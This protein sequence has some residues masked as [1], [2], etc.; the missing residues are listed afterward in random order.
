MGA[1][2]SPPP[3][4]SPKPSGTNPLGGKVHVPKYGASRRQW[5]GY[6]AH[7]K[8]CPECGWENDEQAL[9]CTSCAADIRAIAIEASSDTRPGVAILQKRLERERRRQRRMRP[10]DSAGGGGWIAAGAALI[11]IALVIGP[12]RWISAF[13]W[14]AAVGAAVCGIWQ[15]RR[16]QHAMRMW[17]GFLAGSA[18]LVLVFVGVRAILASESTVDQADLGIAATTMATPSRSGASLS[19]PLAGSVTMAGGG[20]THDGLMPG[21]APD[22]SPVLAWQFDTGGELYAAPTI[23]DGILYVTSKA[24]M[25]HAVDAATGTELWSH[26][27]TTYVT[28]ATPAIVD[29]VVYVGGGFSFMA[30]DAASGST[31]WSIPVQY[32]GQASPT[33]RDGLVVVSS[34]Q[35][36]ILA[37]SADS[38]KIAWR[39]PTEGVVFGA[40][41]ITSDAVIY[42]TDE[43]ILY[44]VDRVSGTL[45]WREDVGGGVYAAPVA[46]GDI[47]LAT[48][49]AGEVHAIERQSGDRLWSVNH[50][51]A[52]SLATNGDIVILAAN[53]G[54]VYGLDVATG[55]QRW[56]Y[57]SG[58]RELTAPSI[59]A[60]QAFIGTGNSL[61]ALDLAT[62]E[63]VWY[64]L[65]GD[66][67]ESAP[68]VLDGYVFFGSRDGFLN[69]VTD[70]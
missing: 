10:D 6:V 27:V 14:I 66:I 45:D 11:V 61:L 8:R 54:G 16:D 39:L 63:P 32:G 56:L 18:A 64:Y 15:I 2:P 29:G 4:P 25:L 44:S 37:L 52:D 70:R 48:T 30:L 1:T 26:E 23:A 20:P 7:I 58:K 33:V 53:D 47:V 69:A 41:A 17:G 68:V 43:G 13:A 35:G 3:Q 34:Q 57:P 36:W 60:G 21:P 67:I 31:I 40:A 59:V 49:R 42:G 5:S 9:F 51:G 46:T 50:G 28:R 65:A 19:D 55:A 38:G 12:D 24:G 62:G 22:A